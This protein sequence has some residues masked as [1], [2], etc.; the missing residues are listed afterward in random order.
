MDKKSWDK[1]IRA[2]YKP[3]VTRVQIQVNMIY[4]PNKS[5]QT[6]LTNFP[7]IKSEIA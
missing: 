1:E 7:D 3:G 6:A 4:D 5:S 2:Q